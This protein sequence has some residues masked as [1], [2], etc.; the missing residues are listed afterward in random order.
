MHYNNDVKLHYDNIVVGS[1]LDAVMFAF[2]ND[3]PIFYTSPAKPFRF[4]YFEPKVKLDFLG[5]PHEKRK[6]NCL[7]TEFTSGIPK[8]ML[9]ERLLFLMSLRGLVPLS[10]LCQKMRCVNNDIVFSNGYSKILEINFTECYYFGDDNSNGFIKRTKLDEQEYICYD[11]IAFNKGGKHEVD[12]IH[13]GDDFVSEIW[14]YSSDRIDGNSPIRDACAVS[15]LKSEQLYDFDFSETMAR[16]KTVKTMKDF[17]MR[18]P[19]NGYT[20]AGTP[21][22]YSIK[23]ASIRREIRSI[24]DRPE[25]STSYIK[26]E[27][28][29]EKSMLRAIE[30]HA[31]S[32]STIL[33]YLYE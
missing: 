9:W 14:F 20:K 5:I 12:L 32:Y 31:K 3:Y 33:G 6:H 23:T 29:C 10:N 28:V 17:G 1:N 4:D 22:H 27:D 18:G 26:I 24:E 16:F 19:Q 2:T 30:S 8:L 21:R 25:P 15:K 13:T 11:Y 7:D